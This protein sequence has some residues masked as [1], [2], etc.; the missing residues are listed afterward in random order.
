[1]RRLV[2]SHRAV[3]PRSPRL[4][5]DRASSRRRATCNWIWLAFSSVQIDVNSRDLY[6][7]GGHA[8]SRR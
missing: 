2:I 4:P 1:M 6:L 7:I 3:Q 5:P 8:C